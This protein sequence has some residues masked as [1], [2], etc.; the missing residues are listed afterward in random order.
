MVNLRFEGELGE[1]NNLV[2]SVRS[3]D[4]DCER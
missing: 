4:D 2:K 1:K 3:G